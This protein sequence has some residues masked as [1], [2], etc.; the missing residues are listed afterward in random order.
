MRLSKQLFSSEMRL[1]SDFST[2]RTSDLLENGVFVYF[3]DPGIPF[4]LPIGRRVLSKMERIFL[5]ESRSLGMEHI[6]I[7]AILRDETLEEGESITDTFK[8]RIVRLNNSSLNGYH[9]LTTPEPMMLDL[10]KHS[11]QSHHQLP[12]RLVYN[13]EVIRGVQKPKGV[14]K[15]RQFKAFMGN[16]FD[17]DAT[18]LKE[19]SQLFG[20]LSERIFSLLGIDV[21]RREGM[22]GKDIEHF[23]FAEEGDNLL[24]PE[25]EPTHRLK[26]LSLAMTYHYNPTKKSG[27]RFRNRQNKNSHIVYETFGLGTQRTFYALFDSHRDDQGFRLPNSVAP[28]P[29]SIIPV[30]SQDLEDAERLYQS[31]PTEAMLDDRKNVT[32]AE[33][34][35]FSDYVGI[36]YKVMVGDG[37][38]TIKDREGNLEKRVEKDYLVS[39]FLEERHGT[40][41]PL[42]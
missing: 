29:V 20:S 30:K 11:L 21:Y 31:I 35:R 9:V 17:A 33:K 27:V 38:Y 8:A 23:Y 24:M 18:S 40:Q 6:E 36:P 32:F 42:L 1:P 39:A 16:S 5:K 7:P 19:S 22:D 28:F 37:N 3:R 2:T 14:L 4:Y 34:A 12:L 13:V 25:I 10:A 15:G 26:A 41:L